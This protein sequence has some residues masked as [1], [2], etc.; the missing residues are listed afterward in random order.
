MRAKSMRDT[1]C[2]AAS[3][4]LYFPRGDVT[5]YMQRCYCFYRNVSDLIILGFAQ[6]RTLARHWHGGGSLRSE[7]LRSESGHGPGAA[8]GSASDAH[9]RV[10]R[11]HRDSHSL[12][13]PLCRSEELW[14]VTARVTVSQ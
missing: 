11:A 8:A 9:E 10:S 13:G 14:S 1:R 2:H 4:S 6:S 7:S 5:A 12:T 3:R